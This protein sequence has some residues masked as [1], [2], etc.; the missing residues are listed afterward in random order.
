MRKLPGV[1]LVVAALLA[2][3]LPAHAAPDTPGWVENAG[4]G[5]GGSSPV[6]PGFQM[7]DVLFSPQRFAGR[8]GVQLDHH[9][10]R[11]WGAIREGSGWR[12]AMVEGFDDGIRW[13]APIPAWLRDPN[14]TDVPFIIGDP[15][16]LAV[17]Y[18]DRLTN[19][20]TF[21]IAYSTGA[22]PS[23]TEP[24][25]A[26]GTAVSSIH[27]AGSWDGITWFDDAAILQHSEGVIAPAPSFKNGALVSDLLVDP[28]RPN[29]SGSPGL[30]FPWHCPFL[31]TYT[32][33]SDTGTQSIAMAG[34]DAYD[35]LGTLFR[36]RT[37]PSLSPGG[38]AWD[39]AILDHGKVRR[40]TEA[41]GYELNYSGGTSAAL[42]CANFTRPCLS[43]GVASSANGV[44][45]SKDNLA[46]P[47]THGDLP[48]FFHGTPPL[49]LSSLQFV[50]DGN[51]LKHAKGFYA[52]SDRNGI[53][54]TWMA[55]TAPVPPTGPLIEVG[56][57]D[58]GVYNHA[59]TTI[60]LFINDDR[61][62]LL[63]LRS[64]TFQL[65]IDGHLVQDL[66]ASVGLA[67]TI[68]GSFV[69][70][71][72]RAQTPGH[73]LMLADGEHTMDVQIRDR[74]DELGT[75]STRFLVDTKPPVSTIT[76]LTQHPLLLGAPFA[77]AALV[78]GTT[79]DEV[80]G[81]TR[82]RAVARNA[83]GIERIYD[84]LDPMGGWNITKDPAQP[85]HAW[86]WSWHPPSSDPF[87]AI[88]G[89]VTIG[90]FAVDVGRNGENYTQENSRT[91]IIL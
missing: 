58:N 50:D 34:G 91:I 6:I 39:T 66:G 72:L 10:W 36:G 51:P 65:R 13:S 38:T 9:R 44:T 80:S 37:S 78:T 49:T 33:I 47:A 90:F 70:P 3:A 15:T 83:A 89:P 31:L 82:I 86:S 2:P 67:P 1:L 69:S 4:N 53:G 55:Y 63:G 46:R 30:N 43:L 21:F 29:C 5:T 68:V 54:S 40:R 62:T 24:G 8:S 48:G 18:Q 19:W 85:D 87:W 88:P 74:D 60:D 57:P 7:A 75:L 59:D 23:A 35:P 71:G 25:L 61:G 32:A 79:T 45:W 56:S 77:W 73:Q 76:S 17:A 84:S 14:G 11:G 20:P 81:I 28:S 41:T 42:D 27:L 22:D 12:L 26:G 52:A 64:E 16:H